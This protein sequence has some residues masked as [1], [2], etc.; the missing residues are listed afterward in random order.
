MSQRARKLVGTFAI[1]GMLV[2]YA[3]I[4]TAIA[5]AKLA[6]ASSWVHL[7]YFG[8]TG[9]LWIIPAMVIISWMSKPDNNC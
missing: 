5:S 6:D 1:L 2:V 7:L 8:L 9:L 3:I 4:A